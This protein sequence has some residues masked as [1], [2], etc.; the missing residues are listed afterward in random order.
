[1]SSDSSVLYKR[2]YEVLQ[3]GIT[4]GTYPPGSR[5]PTEPELMDQFNV[6][7]V[8]VRQALSLLKRVGLVVSI[9]AKGTFVARVTD[10][11]KELTERLIVVITPDVDSGFFSKIIRGIEREAYAGGFHVIVHASNDLV[12]EEERF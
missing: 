9:P 1:M 2:V 11:W 7:R 8:T 6:S 5:L 4:N 10:Q 3:A 12:A